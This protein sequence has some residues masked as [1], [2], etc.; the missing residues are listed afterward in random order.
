MNIAQYRVMQK[1]MQSPI[2]KHFD[3]NDIPSAT[4][5]TLDVPVSAIQFG[6][7]DVPLNV[8]VNKRL[9]YNNRPIE[10]MLSID[11][12]NTDPF[13]AVG[14]LRAL[15]RS[16]AGKKVINYKKSQKNEN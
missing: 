10:Q 5:P 13:D 11:R 15:E 4:D 16:H 7:N 2:I 6:I 3:T 12:R 8:N 14:E 9:A 1:T